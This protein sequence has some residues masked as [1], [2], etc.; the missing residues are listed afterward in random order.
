MFIVVSLALASCKKEVEVSEPVLFEEVWETD[1]IKYVTH[2]EI[3]LPSWF[4]P[5]GFFDRWDFG[6]VKSSDDCYDQS[7][8]EK[9]RLTH[10]S[11]DDVAGEINH[12]EDCYFNY[13]KTDSNVYLLEYS[14]LFNSNFDVES[15]ES[16]NNYKILSENSSKISVF[17][18]TID[19]PFDGDTMYTYLY[20]SKIK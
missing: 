4:I 10:T 20:F 12:S 5:S 19:Y 16:K 2:H 8:N 18:K 15:V 9:Q 1:S 13:K 11:I 7:I 3:G 14:T 17:N 6:Y